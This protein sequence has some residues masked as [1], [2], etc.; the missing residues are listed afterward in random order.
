MGTMI[1]CGHYQCVSYTN[2]RLG[3]GM[4]RCNLDGDYAACRGDQNF[5]EKSEILTHDA[6]RR[7]GDKTS[8]KTMVETNRAR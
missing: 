2:I 4:G 8:L 1:N 7:T 3:I 6:V 5:C